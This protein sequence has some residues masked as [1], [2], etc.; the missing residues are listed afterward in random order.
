MLIDD[1]SKQFPEIFILK[2]QLKHNSLTGKTY[3]GWCEAGW[4]GKFRPGKLELEDL[5]FALETLARKLLFDQRAAKGLL[6]N[7]Y[8]LK[9]LSFF[10]VKFRSVDR[11]VKNRKGRKRGHNDHGSIP[12][13]RLE[14]EA[15]RVGGNLE[16]E[17]LLQNRL[18]NW[19][20]SLISP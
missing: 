17:N 20:R 15:N 9:R 6:S 2:S 12:C 4:K 5:R 14:R 16:N 13:N 19:L 7:R 18:I 1:F 10:L 3:L 11:S 8:F